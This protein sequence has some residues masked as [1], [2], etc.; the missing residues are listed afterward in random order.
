MMRVSMAVRG[1]MDQDLYD[2][3]R[4]PWIPPLP[5]APILAY[6]IAIGHLGL[7]EEVRHSGSRKRLLQIQ[8][9]IDA[10]RRTFHEAYD[11]G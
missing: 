4:I 1:T 11:K 6:V 2:N 8:T 5:R 3:C 10:Y 9:G 7:E